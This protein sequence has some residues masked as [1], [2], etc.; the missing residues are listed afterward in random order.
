MSSRAT[1][2]S[3][4]IFSIPLQGFIDAIYGDLVRFHGSEEFE[5]DLSIVC[6]EQE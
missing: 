5:D 6:L 3:A 4:A 1:A 2:G